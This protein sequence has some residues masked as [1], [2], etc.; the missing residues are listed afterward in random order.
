MAGPAQ[1]WAAPLGADPADLSQWV[2]LGVTEPSQE[3]PVVDRGLWQVNLPAPVELPALDLAQLGARWARV[4]EAAH[5]VGEQ[6]ARAAAGWYPVVLEAARQVEADQGSPGL[7]ELARLEE[8]RCPVGLAHS[9]LAGVL[10]P[11]REAADLGLCPCPR[12][13]RQQAQ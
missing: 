9:G 11:R 6:L 13:R 10:V 1:L 7:A 4:L 3:V 8:D 2:H 5:Q 12:C